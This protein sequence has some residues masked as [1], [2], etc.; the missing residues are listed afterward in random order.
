VSVQLKSSI[1]I[2]VVDEF[3]A[4]RKALV[5][6]LEQLGYE[7]ME[8]VPD[9]YSALVRLKSALF[10]LVITDWEMSKM[11]GLQLLREI[12]ADQMLKHIPVLM[13]T[14]DTNLEN[15]VDAVKAGLNAYVI[16]PVDLT[17]FSVKM[18]NIFK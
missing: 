3:T 17:S 6:T 4:S 13:V 9:G 11:R 16:K 10:D 7:N 18:K 14:E 15:I 12:R 1:K 5:Y 2:L 8:E